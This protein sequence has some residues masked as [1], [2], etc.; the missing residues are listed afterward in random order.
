MRERKEER[1]GGKVEMTLEENISCDKRKIF[2][3]EWN[4]LNFFQ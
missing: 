4:S 3:I 2:R 1:E